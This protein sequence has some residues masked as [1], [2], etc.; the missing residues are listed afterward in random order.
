ML[1]HLVVSFHI[2]FFE[3]VFSICTQKKV[4]YVPSTTPPAV[5]PNKQA[6]IVYIVDG[7]CT[8]MCLVR[9]RLSFSLLFECLTVAS[10]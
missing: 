4:S 7:K 1:E 5:H 3:N 8:K 6:S 9:L 2:S 10:N